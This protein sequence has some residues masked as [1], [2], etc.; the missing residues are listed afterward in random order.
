M[1]LQ[2]TRAKTSLDTVLRN[3]EL[4]ES[5]KKVG[6]KEEVLKSEGRGWREK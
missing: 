4:G 2:T 5:E 3:C 1:W 6:E